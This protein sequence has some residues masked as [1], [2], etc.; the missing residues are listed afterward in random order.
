MLQIAV[1]TRYSP[2]KRC[3][4]TRLLR[5]PRAPS[6]FQPLDALKQLH[7]YSRKLLQPLDLPILFYT[8][9]I[10]SN[11][12]DFWARFGSDSVYEVRAF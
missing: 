10:G 7:F 12:H 4:T 3:R 2:Y 9:G 11:E 8:H 1:C 5:R 6:L